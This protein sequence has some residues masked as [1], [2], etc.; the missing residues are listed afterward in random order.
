MAE[1]TAKSTLV[2]RLALHRY[3]NGMMAEQSSQPGVMRYPLVGQAHSPAL[4][5]SPENV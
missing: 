5:L 2:D 1:A 4:A 3:A